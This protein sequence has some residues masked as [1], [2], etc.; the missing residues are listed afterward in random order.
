MQ[1]SIDEID[2]Q[3]RAMLPNNRRYDLELPSFM[4]SRRDFSNRTSNGRGAKSSPKNVDIQQP[5][6]TAKASVVTT[7]ASVSSK[8]ARAPPVGRPIT[9]YTS[10]G[11]AKPS[12]QQPIPSINVK[13]TSVPEQ[14]QV[15]QAKPQ[16]QTQR[17]NKI[18]NKRA[19]TRDSQNQSTNQAVST[20]EEAKVSSASPRKHIVMSSSGIVVSENLSG[21]NP[22]YDSTDESSGLKRL[23]GK[24]QTRNNRKYNSNKKGSVY[25]W[26]FSVNF[27]V[28]LHCLYYGTVL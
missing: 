19:P 23:P 1:Q 22:D 4:R 11:S 17:R 28:N 16:R 26:P 21:A 20:S 9:D 27:P 2:A 12:Q 15:T 24:R 5:K 25:S 13:P 3:M 6:K 10:Q 8:Q 14:G 18:Q 7:S